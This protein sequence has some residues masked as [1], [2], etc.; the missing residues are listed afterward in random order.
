MVVDYVPADHRAQFVV[1]LAREHL[2]LSEIVAT[3]KNGLGQ[4]PFDPRM[5]TALLLYGYCS[6]LCSSRRIAKACAERVDFMM[7]VAHDAPDFH[8]DFRKRRLP[9]LGRLFLQVLKLAEKAVLAKLGMSRSTAR[10]DELR[11]HEDA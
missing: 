6:G 2:D 1:V 11:T 10:S 7:I 4:P 5:M 8:A 3:Y 9:P